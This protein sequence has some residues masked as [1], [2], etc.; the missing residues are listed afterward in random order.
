MKC[1]SPVDDPK[2]ITTKEYVDAAL[3]G[4]TNKIRSVVTLA[5]D[6]WSDKSQTVNLPG[7][8]ADNDLF[9]APIEDSMTDYYDA[10]IRASAQAAGRLTFM[11]E[12]VPT[13][14]LM[15]NVVI[16]D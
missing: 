10:D 8:T 1:Y 7:V 12:T 13:A 6:G 2:D 9:V 16:F 4:V 3:D 14:S 15:V 11:C 5:A